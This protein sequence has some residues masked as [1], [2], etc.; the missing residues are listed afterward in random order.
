MTR[1]IRSTRIAAWLAAGCAAAALA[2]PARAFVLCARSGNGADP[3]DGA[4]VKVRSACRDNEAAL[5]AAALGVSPALPATLV[6]TGDTISTNGTL[7]TPASCA[8]GEVATGG[9]A[10]TSGTGGGI[11]VLRSSRPQPDDAGATPTAWR[12]VVSNAGDAGT[13]TATTYVVCAPTA[14]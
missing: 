12:V 10:L 2:T 13:I 4:S 9:G 1:T 14:P 8:D 7:S 3:N 5:D 11:P 6:R